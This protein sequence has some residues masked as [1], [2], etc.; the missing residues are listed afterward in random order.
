[1]TNVLDRESILLCEA[2]I[3]TDLLKALRYPKTALLPIKR[4]AIRRKKIP[5]QPYDTFAGRLMN[6]LAAPGP[7]NSDV[8][9][10]DVASCKAKRRLGKDEEEEERG[11]YKI[12]RISEK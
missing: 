3:T 4:P 11:L 2:E 1:V 5:Y 7:S 12:R 10:N 8:H 6:E 9:V